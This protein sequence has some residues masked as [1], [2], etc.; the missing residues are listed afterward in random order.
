MMR[1]RRL[2]LNFRVLTV[3]CLFGVFA[4]S[5]AQARLQ[6]A[7]PPS[8]IVVHL[9]GPNSV[10][11]NVAPALA[12]APGAAPAGS[13][14]APAGGAAGPGWGP[15]L[16]QMFVTGDPNAPN[17]PARGKVGHQLAD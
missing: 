6:P 7:P 13:S 8:G 4:A 5:V 3:A 9:F 2:D 11:Q 14:P 16:H 17:Q 10:L 1:D 15:V 12:D